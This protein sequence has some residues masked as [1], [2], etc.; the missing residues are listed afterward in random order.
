MTEKKI[1][2]HH[3]TISPHEI[4]T[5]IASSHHHID[6]ITTPPHH[7]IITSLHHNITTSVHHHINTSSHHHITTLT[8]HLII[9]SPQHHISIGFVKVKLV[10]MESRQTLRVFLQK[11]RLAVMWGTFC[12]CDGCGCDRLCSDTPYTVK[13]KSEVRI[14]MK[15]LLKVCVCVCSL[16]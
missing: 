7:Y 13:L 9:T 3:I 6:R 2:I 15:R 8:H 11:V 5:A 12:L 1:N 16:G 4:T 14:A 10:R